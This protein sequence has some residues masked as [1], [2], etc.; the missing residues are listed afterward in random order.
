M[1]PRRLTAAE[2]GKGVIQNETEPNRRK[3]RAPS[4]DNSALIQQNLLTII[5]RLVNPR[6]Q[7]I[8]RLL[9]ELPEKWT[10]K[11][12]VT[13]SDL[14]YDR[15][16]LRFEREEDIQNVL[17]NRQYQFNGWMVIL[18]RWEP[19]ISTTFPSQIPFWIS[20]K[21][22]PLHF[23][24]EKVIYE[25]GQDLG[26][27]ETYEITKTSA[28]IRVLLNSL[29]PI[30]TDTLLEFDTGEEAPIT[31]EKPWISLLTRALWNSIS[32][33]TQRQPLPTLCRR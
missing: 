24:H 14:G 11:G 30:V 10:L 2:K 12:T 22:L 17:N 5:G 3:I 28:R 6:E 32:V 1:S 9:D 19:I 23:W 15:F 25:I 33:V 18:Q 29:E 21:G 26:T 13:G 16:H 8:S 20:L 7:S 31:L 4:F 27:L